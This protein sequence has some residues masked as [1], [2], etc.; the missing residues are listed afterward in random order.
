MDSDHSSDSVCSHPFV[1]SFHL[2][3]DRRRKEHRCVPVLLAMARSKVRLSWI[4]NDSTRRATLKKR[5][6]GLLKKVQELSILCGVD[7]CAVV[8]AQNEHQPQMWP[9][10][11]ETA[12]IMTRFKNSS[13]IERTRKMIDQDSFLHQR[14]VKLMEQLRRLQSE[15]KEIRITKL[16]CEGL[17]GRDFDDLSIDDASALTWMAEAKLRMVY[18][19][20]EEDSKRQAMPPPQSQAAAPLAATA[21]GTQQTP[22]APPPPT[23][24]SNPVN[25]G[26]QAVEAVQQPN[27]FT[28]VIVNWSQQDSDNL[29]VDPNPTWSATLNLWCLLHYRAP[30]LQFTHE[31]RLKDSES[32]ASAMFSGVGLVEDGPHHLDVMVGAGHHL[33][34][35]SH[36][37]AIMCFCNQVGVAFVRPCHR[38]MRAR[39]QGDKAGEQAHFT[40]L[41]ILL[42]GWID[43]GARLPEG[44]GDGANP[45]THGRSLRSLFARSETNWGMLNLTSLCSGII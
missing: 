3:K 31:E 33:A 41:G 28:D 16:L 24:W 10:P 32:S 23:G 38:A 11:P 14:V 21:T 30:K 6:K 35:K 43:E 39:K 19:K 2:Y 44:G 20:R 22:P 17:L 4:V 1:L 45:R 34:V 29:L 5:R 25:H 7:A 36:S 12:R 26:Q 27:W 40:W 9:S 13:Q 18:E 8:Y 42:S 37:V 15:N